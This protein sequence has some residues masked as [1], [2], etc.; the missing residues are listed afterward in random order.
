MAALDRY[1]EMV[2][3]AREEAEEPEA[4]MDGYMMDDEEPG[5]KAGRVLSRQN[6]AAIRQAREMAMGLIEALDQLLAQVPDDQEVVEPG[7]KPEV[8]GESGMEQQQKLH[9]ELATLLRAVME[10]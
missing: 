9:N 6:E 3:E 5:M 8:L 4:E 10:G 2:A 7:D 1:R